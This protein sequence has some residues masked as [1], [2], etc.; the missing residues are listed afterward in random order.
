MKKLLM[1]ALVVMMPFAA[2]AQQASFYQLP[3]GSIGRVAYDNEQL[4]LLPP[5]Y[6]DFQPINV[7]NGKYLTIIDGV[8]YRWEKVISVQKRFRLIMLDQL[9]RFPDD[10]ISAEAALKASIA[11]VNQV[12]EKRVCWWGNHQ[13]SLQAAATRGYKDDEGILRP[14]RIIQMLSPNGQIL[15]G[16]FH[17]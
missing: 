17:L 5:G 4:K 14:V 3:P 10:R 2:R 8:C 9:N 16:G 7:S 1:A 12:N 15:Y 11:W 6:H 13:L